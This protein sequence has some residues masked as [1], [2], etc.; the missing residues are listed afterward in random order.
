MKL[1]C[2]RLR[3]KRRNKF[4]C[5]K[6]SSSISAMLFALIFP[7]TQCASTYDISAE[8]N[9]WLQSALRSFAIVC[10]YMETG[11]FAIV[12][13]LRSA[14]CD[15]LRSFAIIWKP[16]ILSKFKQSSNSPVYVHVSP[17]YFR[18]CQL[19][20]MMIEKILALLSLS[21]YIP[22]AS[23]SPFHIRFNFSKEK[24]SEKKIA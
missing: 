17:R 1:T 9:V 22:A 19:N 10:D 21:P 18:A 7:P 16:P 24:R 15:R 4:A 2:R 13:D 23:A 12:C 5:S 3:T 20:D 14:I 11:L 8:R 6:I